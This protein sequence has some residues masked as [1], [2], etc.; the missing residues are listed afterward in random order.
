MDLLSRILYR[1]G[2]RDDPGPHYYE[3][4]ARLH[5]ALEDLALREQRPVTEVV[6]EF[7]ASGLDRRF[8][9]DGLLLHWQS[10]SPREQDVSAFACLGYTNRQ[11]AARLGISGETVKTHLHNAL[12]KFNLH[13]RSELRLFLSQWDFSAWGDQN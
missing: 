13:G 1:L 2:F 7:V 3:L 5:T 9:Q 11:I 12:V 4:N 10:L 6:S 8:S